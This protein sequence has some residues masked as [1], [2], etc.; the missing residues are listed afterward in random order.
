MISLKEGV[1]IRGIRPEMAMGHTIVCSIFQSHALDVVV[2][3]ASDGVHG[4]ASKH[5]CGSALDYRSRHILATG[6]KERIVG[7]M[8]ANLGK[9]FDVVL[10]TDHIHVEFDPKGT[11]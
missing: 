4:R 7:E 11:M 8:K 2:T 1:S 3:S 9:D 10:E 5:Y 6:L